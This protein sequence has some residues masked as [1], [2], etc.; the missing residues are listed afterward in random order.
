VVLYLPKTFS[1][2]YHIKL[3]RS[4]KLYFCNTDST[5][6]NF[7]HI[8]NFQCCILTIS[9]ALDNIPARRILK[10]AGTAELNADTIA[11]KE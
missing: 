10:Q 7:C 9:K 6:N 11:S 3:L 5:T 1:R 4:K 2:Q 8:K